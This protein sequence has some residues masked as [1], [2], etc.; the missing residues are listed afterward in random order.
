MI[1][2]K[3]LL[4]EPYIENKKTISLVKKVL[5]S[6]FP[7]EGKFTK[8]LEKKI[9]KL[10]RVRYVVMTTSGTISIF[11]ALKAAG[12]KRGDEVIVPNLTFPATANAVKLAGASP[13]LVDVNNNNLLIN[14][15][16]LIKKI[17][18]KTK[19]IIPV[20]VSGRGSNIKEILKIAKRKKL[21]HL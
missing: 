15:K 18:K 21:F 20:H 10:L 19:A 12:I 9:C 13:I 6:N 3:I 8:L 2:K 17:N 4:T 11:L 14:E 1:K 5:S 16:S 7:N